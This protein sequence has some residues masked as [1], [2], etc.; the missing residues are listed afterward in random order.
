M[1][2][3]IDQ[4]FK[5][6]LGYITQPSKKKKSKRNERGGQMGQ[7]E[8]CVC[9]CSRVCAWVCSSLLFCWEGGVGRDC[10]LAAPLSFL[11]CE[12]AYQ[13]LPAWVLSTGTCVCSWPLPWLFS[14]GKGCGISHCFFF[15]TKESPRPRPRPLVLSNLRTFAALV[16]VLPLLLLRIFLSGSRVST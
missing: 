5:T 8:R 2:R 11:F 13:M 14:M 9:V 6:R 4:E 7:R 16:F 1:G 12:G 15:P 10:T 3:Q